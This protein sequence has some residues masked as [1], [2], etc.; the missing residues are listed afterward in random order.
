MQRRDDG[1]HHRASAGTAVEVVARSVVV[2]RAGIRHP[3]LADGAHAR[4]AGREDEHLGGAPRAGGNMEAM[5]THIDIE[6]KKRAEDADRI[7]KNID[8]VEST[9]NDVELK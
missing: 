4:F 1:G 3:D 5:H 9:L 7:E 8:T 6:E 2:H